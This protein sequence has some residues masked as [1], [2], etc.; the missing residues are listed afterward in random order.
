M[1]LFFVF[2][3]I[4]N[5]L[6][7]GW[8]YLQPPKSE[9]QI[10]PLPAELQKLQLLAELKEKPQPQV[11][12]ADVSEAVI[13]SPEMPETSIQAVAD[14]CYTLG[15][16]KDEKTLQQVQTVLSEWAQGVAVR[17]RE[18]RQRHRYWVY[19]PA[20]ET[21]AQAV[22]MSKKLAQKN[23]KDYYIVRS[24]NLD[25]GISLGHFKEKA[26]ADRR[27][28]NLK[29]WGFDA[30]IE[31]IYRNFNIF[32]LD[33]RLGGGQKKSDEYIKEFLVEGVSRIDRDCS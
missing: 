23:I 19:L 27:V 9:V 1:R 33:Y 29:K 13:E 20:F 18:E 3:L 24:G 28:S 8:Q 2:L 11:K 25:K 7:A 15:P 10:K 6:F 30:E 14:V 21:R 31:V 4:L 17:K 22:E 32:W 26:Y 16:F 5:L 12:E